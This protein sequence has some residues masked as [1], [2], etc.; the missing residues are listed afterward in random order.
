M[1]WLYPA[2]NFLHRRRTVS[3]ETTTPRSAWSSSTSLK[4]S[5]WYSQT[6]SLM[7]AAGN[8]WRCHLHAI[9]PTIQIA[10]ILP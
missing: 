9:E 3:Q 2:P 5:R 1:S 7:I 8:R 4:L 10:Q 6:A